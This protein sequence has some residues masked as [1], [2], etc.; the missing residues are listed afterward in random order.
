MSSTTR[1]QQHRHRATEQRR[2]ERRQQ[3]REQRRI[4]IGS[5]NMTLVGPRD[6]P[7]P[8]MMGHK[9]SMCTFCKPGE[10]VWAKLCHDKYYCRL[11]GGVSRFDWNHFLGC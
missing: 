5:M 10:N 9:A 4:A 2:Q 11:R 1:S 7:L 8:D 3:D 6:L